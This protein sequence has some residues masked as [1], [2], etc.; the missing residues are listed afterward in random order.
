MLPAA[1]MLIIGL[2]AGL[3]KLGLIHIEAS[4]VR[5]V[6]AP[7]MIFGFVGSLIVLE[8]AV[9][10]RRIWAYSG[11]VF[12]SVGSILLL[13]P[14]TA[15]AKVAIALGFITLLFIY[16]VIWLRQKS[17]ATAIQTLAAFTGLAAVV[18]WLGSIPFEK[19]AFVAATFLVLTIVGERVEL[20]RVGGLTLQ[21]ERVGLWLSTI[22][23]ITSVATIF[24][25][26]LGYTVFG[27]SL[28]AII[29][30]LFTV[31]IA[32]TTVSNKG[33]PRYM[34]L[35]LLL[36]YAWLLVAGFSFLIFGEPQ[37]QMFDIT[38]HS[39][40]LGFV[41]SMIM[42]HASVILPAVLRIKLPYR[43]WF[44]LPLLLLQL[45]LFLRVAGDLRAEDKLIEIGGTG[46]VISIVLFILFA[47]T[48]AALA[49]KQS[50]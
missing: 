4:S 37:G 48:S 8:R 27:A 10:V 13:T 34:A 44:Y 43:S 21:G 15:V 22:T 7:A 49:E 35:A 16:R 33:A 32:R 41:M 2:L 5:A 45:T 46:N 6:H 12:L 20:G 11:P 50:R 23:A 40:L 47:A 30:W 26:E 25:G 28:V 39:I 36:G 1:A 19:I 29:V 14:Q 3:A 24:W 31:D 18:L 17:I 38:I 42:A 9:A